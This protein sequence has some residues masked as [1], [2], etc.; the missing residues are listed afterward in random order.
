MSSIFAKYRWLPHSLIFLLAIGLRLINL[1]GRA[2]WYDEAF[3]VLFAEKGL[4]AMLYGTLTPVVGGAADIHPL[5]Y[6]STL[7]V[8]MHFFGESA[9]TVRLLSVVFGV[10]TVALIYLLAKSLFDERTGLVAALITA[11]APFHVQ[12]SQETRMY[13]L[14]GLL[15]MSATWCFIKSWHDESQVAQKSLW[16]NWRYWLG[17]GL[18]AGLAMYTQQLAAFYLVA[19]GLVPF[20]TR[21]KGQIIGLIVGA[22]TAI[23]VYLPWLV[24]LPGQLQKVQSYYWLDKPTIAT[25]LLTIRS[26]LS[27]NLDFPSPASMIAFFGGLFV[28]LLLVVQVLMFIRQPKNRTQREPILFVLWL[29]MIPPLVM[30]VVSQIQ[31]VYL[32][33]SLLPSA[34]ML[35]VALAWLFM[36]SGMPK[37]VVGIIAALGLVLVG[38]GL[39]YQYTIATFPNSPF[40]VAENYI[41]QNWQVGDVVVHQNKLTALPGIYYQRDL[42]QYFIGD[43]PGSS[44]DTL[45][46][47]TQKAL[48][49]MADACVQAATHQG[50]RVWWMV[51]AQA[52]AQYKVA[53]R[54]E[55][56]Q[57]VAWL[58][59]H[60]TVT[61][62]QQFNDL[63]VVLYSDA[64]G[65]LG[66][67]CQ[68]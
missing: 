55:F 46:L 51:F 50:K 28:I 24:N 43:K 44:D 58:N 20:V 56:E 38:I 27:V 6:Y 65:D 35:Y 9:F 63:N 64:H 19:I 36:R 14:L 22:I 37:L 57:A 45:A 54:P 1:A 67:A 68:P 2:L 16:M 23:V 29:A 49:I 48:N 31:P 60:Y 7:N 33:R 41:A 18:F 66:G 52:E 8:W 15:L 61:S 39:Y 47:P 34:L 21:R 11:I 10:A 30:W 59:E 25:P 12:Y 13:A 5:L 62:T 26:F 40:Q 4:S 3:A 32:E 42:P 17:F 53:N